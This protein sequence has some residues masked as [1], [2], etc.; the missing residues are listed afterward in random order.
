M[1][2]KRAFVAASISG[3]REMLD[4]VKYIISIV[5]EREYE[6]LSL[7]NGSDD[8]VQTF[9]EKTGD[10]DATSDNDFR[11]WDNR[12]IEA[13]D[14]FIAEI[15]TPSHGVG[16]EFEHCRLKPRL[17]LPLTPILCLY[18]RGVGRISPMIKGIADDESYIWVREY[19]DFFSLKMIL[20]AFLETFGK[21]AA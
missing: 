14:I 18:K 2:T 13:A 10:P 15:S 16:A 19:H 6:V 5:E 4:T 7:H 9:L 12:W 1:N 20:V 8:P 11:D 3:G 21:D 17:R